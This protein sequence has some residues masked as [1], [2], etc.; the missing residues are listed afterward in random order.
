MRRSTLVAS[1][2][3]ASCSSSNVATRS[4]QADSG[5]EGSWRARKKR[6]RAASTGSRGEAVGVG[7][8]GMLE[9][10]RCM[11]AWMSRA[12]AGFGKECKKHRRGSGT[13]RQ[14]LYLRAFTFVYSMADLKVVYVAQRQY[15]DISTNLNT[16]PV[17]YQPPSPVHP[18]A[19]T[20]STSPSSPP[21]PP[22]PHHPQASPS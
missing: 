4:S 19:N 14:I 3:C 2:S 22:Q 1:S 10:V 5:I 12:W 6:S 17:T 7:L 21:A 18:F 20:P 9:C 8:S 15:L 13:E 11:N 16:F